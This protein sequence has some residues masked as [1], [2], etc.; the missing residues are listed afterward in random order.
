[1]KFEK[2]SALSFLERLA[3]AYYEVIPEK[4]KA[5]CILNSQICQEVLRHFDIPAFLMPAQLWYVTEDRNYVVGFVGNT[6]QENVWDGHVVCATQEH[7]FDASL[8][9]LRNEHGLDV[10]DLV[11]AERFKIPSHVF[12]RRNLSDGSRLW[13]HD[14]PAVAQRHPVLED[15]A[16]V[17][18]F[19]R[20]LID[21]LEPLYAA[22]VASALAADEVPAAPPAA[23]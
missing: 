21:H 18:S 15:I 11:V 9:H 16:L 23:A 20:D 22:D 17:K 19:A 10:P 4:Y 3:A 5:Y 1:M 8:I 2:L 7:I 6:P 12:A 14:A 13:W